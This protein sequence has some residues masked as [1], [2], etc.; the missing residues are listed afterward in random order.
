MGR[1]VIFGACLGQ[2]LSM[3]RSQA[4]RDS[5]EP[6]SWDGLHLR[7]SLGLT[8][9]KEGLLF[10]H[11]GSASDSIADHH[12][13]FFL[14]SVCLCYSDLPPTPTPTAATFLPVIEFYSSSCEAWRFRKRFLRQGE[15][16]AGATSPA[17]AL[18]PN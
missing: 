17:K 10:P 12:F 13:F 9:S 1:R 2:A 18:V 5:G 8:V 6:A 11:R 15:Y 3:G 4:D 14:P 16:G 7:Q